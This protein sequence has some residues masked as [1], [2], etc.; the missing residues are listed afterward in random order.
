MK[1][2]DDG[3]GLA[4]ICPLCMILPGGAETWPSTTTDAQFQTLASGHETAPR[5]GVLGTLRAP[6][7][8]RAAG[9]R[10]R[11]GVLGLL[12]SWSLEAAERGYITGPLTAAEVLQVLRAS[13][14]DIQ[15]PDDAGWPVQPGWDRR[16]RC[17]PRPRRG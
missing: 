14:S 15:P 5:Q 17:C 2:D 12:Q 6:R 11:V 16:R 13:A 8:T 1:V 4:G 7:T 10:R 9:C 3:I